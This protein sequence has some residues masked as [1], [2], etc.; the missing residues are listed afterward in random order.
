MNECIISVYYLSV[1]STVPAN[2]I[3]AINCFILH[4]TPFINILVFMYIIFTQ[5]ININ[6]KVCALLLCNY[7]KVII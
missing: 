2:N 1:F 6:M 4:V 3:F 7:H 5:V